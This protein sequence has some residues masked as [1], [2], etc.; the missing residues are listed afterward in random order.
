VAPAVE[1]PRAIDWRIE[2]AVVAVRSNVRIL[3]DRLLIHAALAHTLIGFF[4]R[5]PL[6]SPLAQ[7]VGFVP[8]A[9]SGSPV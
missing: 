1:P 5:A 3:L 4:R 6:E 9:N 8:R 7:A 2:T